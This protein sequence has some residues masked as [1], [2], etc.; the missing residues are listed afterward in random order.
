MSTT[1]KASKGGS[2]LSRS[3][4]TTVRLDPKLRYL[5]ELAAR[6]QRRT[7]SSF[8]EWSIEDSLS[9]LALKEG[10][11][12][13]TS[14]G[15]EAENLW[16]VDAADRLVKLAL[17]YPELLTHEEQVLWKLIRE[18]GYL[19][20]GQFGKTS[21]QWEWV[22]SEDRFVFARLR[23]HWERF[24]AVAA[25]E[26]TAVILPTWHKTEAQEMAADFDEMGLNVHV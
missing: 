26:Q 25:G 15:S 9:R 23:E 4:V 21:K 19:W 18:N 20:A 2:K 24:L 1:T 22:L 5:A 16:D 14:V 17:R 6:K 12:W 7:L 3:E 8:I 11:D 13:L 10:P